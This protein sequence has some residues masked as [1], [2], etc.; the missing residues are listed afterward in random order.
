MSAA[1]SAV[2]DLLARH[3]IR[4]RSVQAAWGGREHH[5]CKVLL[6]DGRA[7]VAKVPLAH[8]YRPRHWPDGGTSSP[9]EAEAEAIA[10]VR[11]VGVATPSLILDG[12]PPIALQPLLPGR[13]PEQ[14]L[15]ERGLSR[16]S[17]ETLCW[18]MGRVMATI[19]RVKRP[20]DTASGIPILSGADPD[21]ARLLHMDFHLGNVVGVRDLRDGWRITGVVD[22]TCCAWGPRTADF[23]ELGASLFATNPW[24]LDPFLLG[25]REASGLRMIREHVQAEMAEA[26]AE[27]LVHEPPESDQIARLWKLRIAEW[28]PKKRG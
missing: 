13:P 28:G 4:A 1:I 27:R 5:V 15:I 3:G 18:Q 22:W 11:G 8:G 21:R 20:A 12:E 10:L 2:R 7:M 9:L 6:E 14:E 17:V 16:A 25:Y 19:H 24:G 23:V 26:L